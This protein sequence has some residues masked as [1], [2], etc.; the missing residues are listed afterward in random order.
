MKPN[1]AILEKANNGCQYNVIVVPDDGNRSVIN[2]PHI[3]IGYIHK[4]DFISATI[5]DGKFADGE[6]KGVYVRDY[7]DKLQSSKLVTIHLVISRNGFK[8]TNSK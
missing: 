4:G 7:K 6:H 2:Y 5:I 8:L 1:K 3:A